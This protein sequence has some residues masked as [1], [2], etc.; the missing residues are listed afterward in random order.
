VVP[1][2]GISI[3]H[4]GCKHIRNDAK[5]AELPA[6]LKEDLDRKYGAA[7]KKPPRAAD[8]VVAAVAAG[9]GAAGLSGATLVDTMRRSSDRWRPGNL[10]SDVAKA[11]RD[12]GL[13]VAWARE[14]AICP[15]RTLFDEFRKDP[16][17]TFA[18]YAAAYAEQL[19]EADGA[20]L[21]VAAFLT[22]A[23][24]ARGLFPTFYCTDPYVPGYSPARREEDTPYAAR[25]YP[26]DEAGYFR[27]RGCHRVVLAECLARFFKDMGVP[28]VVHELDANCGASHA[29]AW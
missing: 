1:G 6:S 18:A 5:L 29:R 12:R 22:V 11:L 23:A 26:V 25:A 13:E 17:M 15:E 16:S 3:A 24:L 7:W 8:L 21:R 2:A 9:V 4:L 10:L 20:G 19:K 27:E 28:V 14:D